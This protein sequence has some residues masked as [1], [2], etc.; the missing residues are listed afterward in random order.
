VLWWEV[1]REGRALWQLGAAGGLWCSDGLALDGLL[2]LVWASW[3][4]VLC[5]VCGASV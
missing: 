4:L 1:E 2:G 5:Q 3:T